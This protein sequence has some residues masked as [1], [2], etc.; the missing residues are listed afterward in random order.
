MK[1]RGEI[2]TEGGNTVL[3]IMVALSLEFRQASKIPFQSALLSQKADYIVPLKPYLQ[4]RNRT[5]GLY[6]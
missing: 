6:I 5:N 4:L 2:G 3:P 1:I